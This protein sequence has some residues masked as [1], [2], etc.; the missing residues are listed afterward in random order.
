MR[1][2]GV[3]VSF[4][5]LV[6]ALGQSS[7][8]AQTVGAGGGVFQA[9]DAGWV[10]GKGTEPAFYFG[11]GFRF[12]DPIEGLVT[13]GVVG[14]G[15]C[16]VRKGRNFRSIECIGIGRGKRIPF[17]NFQMDPLLSNAS[18][19]MRSGGQD[20]EVEWSGRG[21][22]PEGFLSSGFSEHGAYASAGAARGARAGGRVFGVTVSP[23]VSRAHFAALFAGAEGGA[24]AGARR[25]VQV[26]EDGR[27]AYRVSWRLGHEASSAALGRV[28]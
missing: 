25:R 13:I 19:R 23:K 9:A 2:R 4:V 12:T 3:L 24:F 22:A 15:R 1:M 10:V 26:M 6:A 28:L 17:E 14:K 20:H 18:L 27:I 16:T 5:M 7:A 8:A 21:R 11:L